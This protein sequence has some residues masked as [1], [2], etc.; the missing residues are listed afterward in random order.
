MQTAAFAS[1]ICSNPVTVAAMIR[2]N[3]LDAVIRAGQVPRP[4]IRYVMAA[5]KQGDF[6]EYRRIRA[7]RFRGSSI[8]KGLRFARRHGVES[9]RAADRS[10]FLARLVRGMSDV[11]ERGYDPVRVGGHYGY[12]VALRLARL[13]RNELAR[14]AAG[15][16]LDLHV[17]DFS[18]RAASVN[19][20][21]HRA[22]SERVL[23]R[24]CKLFGVTSRELIKDSRCQKY[25]VPRCF[26]F[27]WCYRIGIRH[28]NGVSFPVLGRRMG[29]RDHT[30]ALHG[31]RVWPEKRDAARKLI[32]VRK[33]MERA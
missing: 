32:K 4:V 13:D 21:S 28:R 20:N 10:S 25:V 33:Q 2:A 30:T 24:T 12:D 16:G 14:E 31:I 8:W 18:A 15:I 1:R 23:R 3:G 5:T 11:W 9:L 27:Y 6:L 26:Y 7:A 19:V 29:G 22:V 17:I